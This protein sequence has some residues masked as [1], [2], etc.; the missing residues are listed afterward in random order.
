MSYNA[1][2]KTYD[3]IIEYLQTADQPQCFTVN[4]LP[5]TDEYSMWIG[6]QPY[7]VYEKWIKEEE[8]RV[9][10]LRWTLLS[11]IFKIK[12]LKE[13]LIEIAYPNMEKWEDYKKVNGSNVSFQ[14]YL[15]QLAKDTLSK[16]LED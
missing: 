1:N 8:E 10:E 9:K 11:K 13:V 3:E 12:K 6:N 15:K 16:Y 5:D 7:Y 2:F 14:E 4:Y